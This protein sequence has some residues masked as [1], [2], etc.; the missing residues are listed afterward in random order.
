MQQ[1]TGRL[2]S[3][4]ESSGNPG[5][6]SYDQPGGW[7]YGS[8][9]IATVP[10]TFAAFLEFARHTSPDTYAALD[11]AGGLQ[12]ATVGTAQFKAAWQKLAQ[13][14]RQAF[15]RLQYGY[16]VESHYGAAVRALDQAGYPLEDRSQAL[17]EVIF[18]LAVAAGPGSCKP[19]KAGVR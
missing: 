17:A 7:S 1:P 13:D 15:A 3:Q 8:Y 9:Q 18:S 6:I 19:N 4:N 14:D 2:S 11:Q 12:G 16:I 5:A 10:G